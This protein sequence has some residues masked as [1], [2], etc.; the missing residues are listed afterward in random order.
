MSLLYALF[1][2]TMAKI[3]SES[4]ALWLFRRYQV[5]CK[6]E[7][8]PPLPPP[9]SP[10]CYLYDCLSFWMKKNCLSSC[11]LRGGRGVGCCGSGGCCR[12]FHGDGCRS[13]CFGQP[14]GDKFV[15]AD[16]Q[17]E[18]FFWSQTRQAYLTDK[19]EK[20]RKR[21][22]KD[23]FLNELND[24]VSANVL[25]TKTL[26]EETSIHTKELLA[27]A[28]TSHRMISALEATVKDKD[29]ENRRLLEQIDKLNDE[30]HR[31]KV[32]VDDSRE[33]TDQ[34]QRNQ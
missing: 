34:N 2:T 32:V 14:I 11:C 6:F 26:T 28:L 10:L 12:C 7:K 15:H 33:E 19:T 25:L 8:S 20:E 9:L 27:D 22:E 23:R 1:S 31:L 21:D 17:H 3:K 29:A 4:Q 5:I 16:S 18:A 13:C 30:V 24:A